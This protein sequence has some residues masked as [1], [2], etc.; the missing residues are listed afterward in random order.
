MKNLAIVVAAIA[1]GVAVI[2]QPK[3]SAARHPK[4]NEQRDADY[5]DRLLETNKKLRPYHECL[6]KNLKNAGSNVA[7]TTIDRACKAMNPACHSTQTR[8]EKRGKESYSESKSEDRNRS[9]PA[10]EAERV[11]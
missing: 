11:W 7:A 5:A 1:I 10:A 2:P 3:E 4:H 6:L 8:K 9:P